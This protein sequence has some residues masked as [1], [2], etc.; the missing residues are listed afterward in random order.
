MV[1]YVYTKFRL[2]LETLIFR[3]DLVWN[4]LSSFARYCAVQ[5]IIDHISGITVL[6]AA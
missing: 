6:C 4:D 5:A 3:V 1:G 2:N